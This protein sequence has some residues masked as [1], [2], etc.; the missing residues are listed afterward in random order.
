MCGKF[1]TQA[2]IEGQLFA[3]R[4]DRIHDIDGVLVEVGADLSRRSRRS[5][6]KRERPRARLLGSPFGNI[7][8]TPSAPQPLG[9]PL[10]EPVDC[11]QVDTIDPTTLDTRNPVDNN[12][13]H[14]VANSDIDQAF[15]WVAHRTE[16][17]LQTKRN[18]P[19]PTATAP[20]TARERERGMVNT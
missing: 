16:A 10:A 15:D 1:V 3:A 14:V 13:I 7:P 19:P 6:D 4:C 2:G 5:A 9:I 8:V 20:Q 11:R 18:T 17:Q 12:G